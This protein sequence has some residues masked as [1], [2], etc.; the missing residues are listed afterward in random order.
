MYIVSYSYKRARDCG[1]DNYNDR[2][3]P[4]T[5]PWGQSP[6]GSCCDSETSIVHPLC[7]QQYYLFLY[8]YNYKKN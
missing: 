1:V 5:R 2:P 7:K 8:I 6:N 3:P 4:S